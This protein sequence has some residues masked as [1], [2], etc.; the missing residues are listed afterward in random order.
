MVEFRAHQPQRQ[1]WFRFKIIESIVQYWTIH[2]PHHLYRQFRHVSDQKHWHRFEF[3]STFLDDEI[4]AL[5]T[6][7]IIWTI[8][9]TTEIIR[10]YLQRKSLLN[11]SNKMVTLATTHSSIRLSK[12]HAVNWAH[13]RKIHKSTKTPI[14]S[15][16]SRLLVI[17][18]CLNILNLHEMNEWICLIFTNCSFLYDR[19]I[20][21]AFA[22]TGN[23]SN[24]NTL[25]Q[26]RSHVR[27]VEW[28]EH[29]IRKFPI[30]D[31]SGN[32]SR[33]IGLHSK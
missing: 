29:A 32:K 6:N 8:W 25:W 24:T 18:C 19:T 21:D 27:P 16:C 20:T 33:R 13:I 11:Q 14:T 4:P 22:R 9:T 31:A 26:C 7:S 12:H 10:T 3:R 17:F 5:Q 23:S 30:H 15:P 2:K 1:V 28:L